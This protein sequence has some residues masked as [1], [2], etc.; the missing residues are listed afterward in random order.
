M[1]LFFLLFPAFLAWMSVWY[2]MG[3]DGSYVIISTG[4]LQLHRLVIG[5]PDLSM[6]G[7]P[8]NSGMTLVLCLRFPPTA[9]REE[10]CVL[11]LGIKYLVYRSYASIPPH[12]RCSAL[13]C[14]L[15]CGT[16]QPSMYSYVL[17]V[18]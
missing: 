6:F 5:S 8:W 13:P 4:I 10:S 15:Q 9:G 11:V 1:C 16:A 17:Y 3:W 18:L 2:G 7:R 14:W 12:Q